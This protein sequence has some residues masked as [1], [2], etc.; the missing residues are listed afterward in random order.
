MPAILYSARDRAVRVLCAQ[1]VVPKA[2]TIA[3]FS[4]IGLAMIPGTGFLAAAVPGAFDGWMLLL[5]DYGTRA[6]EEVLTPAIAYAEN[7][8]PVR[9]RLTMALLP[10]VDLFKVEW[11]S[12]AE[13]WL[14]G[15][16]PPKPWTLHRTPAV[17]AP[18]PGWAHHIAVSLSET[19]GPQGAD[20][21]HTRITERPSASSRRACVN[22]LTPALTTAQTNA[23][24]NCPDGF[25]DTIGTDPTAASAPR[26]P[27]A[28]SHWTG[29]TCRGSTTRASDGQIESLGI[30]A[31]MRM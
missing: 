15:G 21:S 11:P 29:T 1:G 25:I 19:G 28:V 13:V 24:P 9:P 14:P 23:P 4:A 17:G 3:K 6:I 31:G 2:A 7:G 27:S 30:P 5:R 10:M 22:G 18:C 20:G 8:F 16:Q 26:R 12:S